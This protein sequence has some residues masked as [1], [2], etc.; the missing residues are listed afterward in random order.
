MLTDYKRMLYIGKHT[1]HLSRYQSK[2]TKNKQHENSK[3]KHNQN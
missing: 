2:T 1:L 3:E